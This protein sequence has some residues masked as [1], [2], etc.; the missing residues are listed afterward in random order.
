MT[1]CLGQVIC[2]NITQE[3]FTDEIINEA[4]QIIFSAGCRSRDFCHKAV[5]S[6]PTKR[7]ELSICSECCSTTHDCNARLCGAEKQV[8]HD[9]QLK[10]MSCKHATDISA[11]R[12]EIT[13]DNRTQS[14]CMETSVTEMHII[15]INGGCCLKEFCHKAVESLPTKRDELSIC[16]E[17]CSNADYCNQLICSNG[18]RSVHTDI[19]APNQL[20]CR[21]CDKASNIS[22]CN[23][24]ALCDHSTQMCYMEEIITTDLRLE[25]HGGCRSKEMCHTVVKRETL[26]PCSQCCNSSDECNALLCGLSNSSHYIPELFQLQCRVCTYVSEVRFCDEL[27]LCDNRTQECFMDQ[28]IIESLTTLYSG[29]CRS[30]EQCRGQ[31]TPSMGKRADVLACSRCC[32]DANDCNSLLC[33]VAAQTPP[34]YQLQCRSC[35]MVSTLNECRGHV[36]CDK[37]S[38]SCCMDQ[39]ITDDFKL[40]YSGGCCMNDY[41]NGTT[42][43]RNGVS[44]CSQCCNDGDDCNSHMCGYN[45]STTD[46]IPVQYQLKCRSLDTRFDDSNCTQP[47]IC[48]NRLEMCFMEEIILDTY[49]IVRRGGCRS[50]QMCNKANNLSSTH[51]GRKDLT[52]CSECCDTTDD[53]NANLCGNVSGEC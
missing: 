8:P 31:I 27:A 43:K 53:C 17:C 15:E 11:C 36:M 2:D 33:G 6:L 47:A 5:E 16:S 44:V 52:P 39:I 38:Q 30:R 26:T 21:L 40:K 37:R 14:C 7:D 22:E 48:D 18:N 42:T 1:M 49:R 9:F 4:L 10:C 20:K 12:H 25:L 19:P 45:Y 32:S 34:S 23:R 3:C 50:K 13:C 51:L 28:I 46:V 35:D 41:C 29:G 24:L